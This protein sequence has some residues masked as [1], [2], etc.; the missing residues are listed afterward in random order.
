MFK[1]SQVLATQIL[2][3]KLFH[4]A[5]CLKPRDAN[6]V[7]SRA[8]EDLWAAAAV[9]WKHPDTMESHALKDHKARRLFCGILCR[10]TLH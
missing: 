1:I 4:T 5:E 6:T 9:I 3:G 10:P 2:S 8:V 7:L